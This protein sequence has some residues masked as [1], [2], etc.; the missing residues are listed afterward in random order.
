MYSAVDLSLLKKKHRN[1]GCMII[2]GGEAASHIQQLKGDCEVIIG[3]NHHWTRYEGINPDYMVY[4]DPDEWPWLKDALDKFE[5]VTVSLLRKTNADIRLAYNDMRE[6]VAVRR[7]GLIGIWFA[8]QITSR[9]IY[10]CGFDCYK[11]KPLYQKEFPRFRR[12]FKHPEWNR[13]VWLR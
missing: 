12:F 9:T 1:H 6:W 5:G 4:I 10:L 7:S 8:L 2:G 3:C 11:G 13:V